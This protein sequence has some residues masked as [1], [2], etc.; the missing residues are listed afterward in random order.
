MSIFQTELKTDYLGDATPQALSPTASPLESLEAAYTQERLTFQNLSDVTA[1]R[2]YW[3]P[4]LDRIEEVTGQRP[5]RPNIRNNFEFSGVRGKIDDFA[6]RNLPSFLL[7]DTYAGGVASINEIISQYPELEQELGTKAVADHISATE[8]L[9]L[10]AEQAALG[11]ERT[12][13]GEVSAFVGALGAEV[14]LMVQDPQYGAMSVVAG[15]A[16]K[17]GEHAIKNVARIAFAEGMIGA[18]L[19]VV[20]SPGVA[21]WR[22]TVG[23]DYDANTFFLSVGTASLGGIA[24]GGLIATPIEVLA[25]RAEKSVGGQIGLELMRAVDETTINEV[26]V[27]LNMLNERQWAEGLAALE[28]AGVEL[29]PT[30][31]G[32]QEEGQAQGELINDNP[33]VDDAELEHLARELEAEAFIRGETETLPPEQPAAPLRARDIYEADNLDGN[34]FRFDPDDLEVDARTF[35]YKSTGD[36]FGVTDKYRQTKTWDPIK[37]GQVIVYEYADGRRVIADGHQRLGMAKRIKASDPSQDP[38]MYGVLLRENDGITPTQA[39]TIAARKNITEGM[40]NE[41]GS[42]VLDVAKLERA[43]PGALSD[44]SL[45]V[46]SSLIRQARDLVELSDEAFGA[47][48]NEVVPS[49][50][51]AIVG[52]LVKDQ[53]KQVPILQVLAD[54]APANAT[55]AEAIV[56]QAMASEFDEAIQV[57]LFGE[58]LVKTSLFNERAQVLDAALKQLRRDRNVFNSL[59]E[60]RARI[61]GEGNVLAAVQNQTRSEI[62]G[63]AIQ[64]IQTIANRKGD[65]SDALTAAARTLNETGNAAAASRSFVDA[66]RTAVERGDFN[67]ADVGSTGRAIDVAEEGNRLAASPARKELEGFDEPD[68][69]ALQRQADQLERDYLEPDPV[70]REGEQA[71]IPGVEQV[72]DAQRAQLEVDRPLRGGDEPMTAGLFDEDARAQD[73]LLDLIPMTREASDGT[74]VTETVSRRQLV[75]EIEQDQKMIDRF[76]ECVV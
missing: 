19:E 32:A 61:E 67:G 48:I 16:R 63:T 15:G 41:P 29:S 24:L 2:N 35:Q 1:N 66:V 47:V 75:D 30:A 40:A 25:R 18:G 37:A 68:S 13:L 38:I 36:Q 10:D 5:N 69:P 34:V 28:D 6:N 56:R 64:L 23:L 73:D 65:L 60:N 4:I 59:V 50:Y 7:P 45:P 51:A 62:D 27:R 72:T 9:A 20:K 8:Q 3:E 71:L 22:K 42:K 52:R 57:G 46:G 55:Q 70:A 17:V 74:P 44:P 43:V 21:S 14:R 33:L 53:D 58:E 49:N 12:T 39:M 11:Q 76:K 26:H 31:R 54:T